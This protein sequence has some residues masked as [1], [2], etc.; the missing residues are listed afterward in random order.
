[1]P[2]NWLSGTFGFIFLLTLTTLWVVLTIVWIVMPFYVIR[3]ANDIRVLRHEINTAMSLVN[4]EIVRLQKDRVRRYRIV[5]TDHD[6]GLKTEKI[7]DAVD[8]SDAMALA[9]RFGIIPKM[10][11][12]V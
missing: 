12:E 8:D 10:V 9:H 7:V 3:M 11:R 6:S 5:G 1:M 4:K 2:E